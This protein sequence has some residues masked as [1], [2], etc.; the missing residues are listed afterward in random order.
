MKPIINTLGEDCREK[1]YDFG[2]DL[3]DC[4]YYVHEECFKDGEWITFNKYWRD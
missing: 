3:A 4:R 1:V 2:D